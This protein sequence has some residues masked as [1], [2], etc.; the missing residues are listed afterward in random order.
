[1]WARCSAWAGTIWASVPGRRAL[2]E[3]WIRRGEDEEDLLEDLLEGG[4]FGNASLS[5]RHS[6]N[7]TLAAVTVDRGGKKRRGGLSRTLFPDREYMA[8]HY[9]YVRNFLF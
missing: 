8:V 6:S 1:M 4:V 5:R 2:P 3:E 9:P 7:L